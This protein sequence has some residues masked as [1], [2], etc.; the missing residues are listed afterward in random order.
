MIICKRRLSC[1]GG[2]GRIMSC[3]EISP[4]SHLNVFLIDM[5]QTPPIIAQHLCW[6]ADRQKSFP[7]VT[8][9]AFCYIHN[10]AGDICSG[11]RDAQR[12]KSCPQSH[13]ILS[14][15]HLAGE[16]RLSAQTC[17]KPKTTQGNPLTSK[18]VMCREPYADDGRS[19]LV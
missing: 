2:V 14:F 17:T 1:E 8:S 5:L 19:P 16:K 7:N 11:H 13:N 4:D 15:I 10:S 18:A 3:L 6:L 12:L 9:L